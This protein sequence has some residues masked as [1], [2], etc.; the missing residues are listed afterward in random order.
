MSDTPTHPVTGGNRMCILQNAKLL[1]SLGLDVEFLYVSNGDAPEEDIAPTSA[2]WD[3]KF[4]LFKT[5]RTQMF[6]RRVMRRLRPQMLNKLDFWYPKRLTHYVNQLQIRN[7][8]DGIIVN[9]VWLSKLAK[10]DIPIKALYTHDVF[11]YRGERTGSWVWRSFSA[12]EEA[13][14]IRRF[15]NV[16]AIQQLEAT[17]FRFIAPRSRVRVIYSPVEYVH[18]P[19]IDSDNIMFFSGGG[20]L[21][22][23]GI[24][25]FIDNVW[26][27]VVRLKPNA[28]LHIGGGICKLLEGHIDSESICLRGFYNDPKEFYMI[29]NVAINPVYEGT[30]LKI[31]TIEGMAH[32]KYMVCRS[33]SVE[34]IYDVNNAPLLWTDDKTE[35]ADMILRGLGDKNKISEIKSACEEY[36]LRYNEYIC[37]EYSDLFK[38]NS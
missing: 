9:Y 36:I 23:N 10:C 1:Q 3:D 24:K 21:N 12:G 25:W 16:L 38:N 15:K 34:G 29:G 13:K 6:L 18:T 17:Y 31:K 20:V 19:V 32:G 33:H 2:Y 4:H 14:G 37:N 5:G 35:Y 30:G 28:K 8:Y 11:T 7:K 27:I 22:Y 26:P